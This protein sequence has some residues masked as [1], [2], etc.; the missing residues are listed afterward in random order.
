[1]R[2]GHAADSQMLTP[3]VTAAVRPGDV[4]VVKG[5]A[6]TRT[7]LI[8]RSLLKLESGDD[9]AAPKRAVNDE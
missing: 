8:V 1:M 5:S 3:M 9:A 7:G 6:G 2:G 4:I